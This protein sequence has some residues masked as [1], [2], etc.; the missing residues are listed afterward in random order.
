[1]SNLPTPEEDLAFATMNPIA[2]VSLRYMNEST[3]SEVS[4]LRGR[5]FT[6]MES[7]GGSEEVI[8]ARKDIV[9]NILETHRSNYQDNNAYNS[10]ELDRLLSEAKAETRASTSDSDITA[11]IV[12]PDVSAEGFINPPVS[13]FG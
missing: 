6:F 1:M 13:V 9:R 7:I 8:K 3:H 4:Y 10:R 2:Q 12:W 11:V 5:L